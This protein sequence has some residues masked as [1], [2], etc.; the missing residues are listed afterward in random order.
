MVYLTKSKDEHDDESWWWCCLV[1]KVG[2]REATTVGR[3][4]VRRPFLSNF[5]TQQMILASKSSCASEDFGC[6]QIPFCSLGIDFRSCLVFSHAS[7]SCVFW[8]YRFFCN[9]DGRHHIHT[10][11]NFDFHFFSFACMFILCL[12]KLSLLLQSLLQTSHIKFF[13][14]K[15]V[16]SSV[17]SFS[18]SSVFSSGFLH[19]SSV[20]ISSSMPSPKLAFSIPHQHWFSCGSSACVS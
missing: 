7:P 2:Q 4:V 11:S 14:K 6:L 19:S 10:S 9:L 20:Q 17:P 5:L 13:T 1:A 15:L 8:G 16:L 12:L 3:A 18:P